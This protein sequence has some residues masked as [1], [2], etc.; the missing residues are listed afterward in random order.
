MLKSF[1]F[2]MHLLTPL[3][4]KSR[5]TLNFP[6]YVFATRVRPSQEEIQTKS[7]AKQIRKRIMRLYLAGF[8]SQIFDARPNWSLLSF[9]ANF[10]H[11]W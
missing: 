9:M 6:T 3:V 5:P 10:L 7:I 11:E 4:P 8:S 2:M 1:W